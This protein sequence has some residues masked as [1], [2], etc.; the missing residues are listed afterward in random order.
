MT[1]VIV[2]MGIA[3]ALVSSLSVTALRNAREENTAVALA[4]AREA[5]IG[6]AITYGDTHTGQVHGYLPCPDTNGSN[7]EGSSPLGSCGSKN[8]S[9]LGRLPWRTLGLAPLRD[10]DGECLWYAVSG[11]Y[12]NNPQTGLMNWDTN[13]Q[14]QAFTTNGT[15]LD[16]NNNQVVAVIFAPGRP[17]GAQNRSGSSAPLCGGNYTAS[18]YL[19]N[20]TARSINNGSVSAVAS[21]VS[22]FIQGENDGEVN[23]RMLF[24]TRQDLWNAMQKRSDFTQ[25][26]KD[27]ARVVAE[28]LADYGNNNDWSSNKSLPWPAPLSLS[29]Y[30]VNSNYDDDNNRYAGRVPY[31][32]NTSKSD[33][34]NDMSGSNLMTSGN[35]LTCPYS[36]ASPSNELERLYPWWDNWKDHLFYALSNEYRPRKAS[37][38]SCWGWGG[39]CVKINGS[40][41]YAAIVLFSGS[42]L[43]GQDRAST[44]TTNSERGVLSNYLEGR[45]GSN[46]PNNSGNGNY[47]TGTGSS[48]FN[49]IL[50]CIETNL[51]VTECPP[52]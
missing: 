9:Q 2:I 36:A 25:K 1:M 12:K 4:Q 18:A 20:N 7:G 15:R 23:D 3:A 38:N 21:A 8:V 32:V 22:Q 46:Y 50:Y 40:S 24:I 29:D 17:Q 41:R 28:C 45:N 30:A 19:D 43:S 26:L 48:T 37:T 33:S 31:R 42:A 39:D 13:G 14:L 5:L 51:N 49:D 52:P 44:T 47:Q 11:T 35:G 6:Y 27:M 34:D 10:G 16:S